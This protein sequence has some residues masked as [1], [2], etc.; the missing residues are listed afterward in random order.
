M[1]VYVIT[2]GATALPMALL[3]LALPQALLAG[4]GVSIISSLIS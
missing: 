4:A 1:K 3:E 2:T